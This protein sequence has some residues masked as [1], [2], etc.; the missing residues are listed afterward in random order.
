MQKLTYPYY[1]KQHWFPN[2]NETCIHHS[3]RQ[4]FEPHT[5]HLL[6]FL[7]KSPLQLP[8]NGSFFH[9]IILFCGSFETEMFHHIS[10]LLHRPEHFNYTVAAGNRQSEYQQ[11]LKNISIQWTTEMDLKLTSH[12]SRMYAN[13]IYC[14]VHE[15]LVI[16]R[17]L[18]DTVA[19]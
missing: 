7:Y 19:T 17:H 9:S 16:R 13:G 8:H 12:S 5:V 1:G 4:C 18:E 15:L 6:Q 11:K 3:L 2:Y 14:I 10:F